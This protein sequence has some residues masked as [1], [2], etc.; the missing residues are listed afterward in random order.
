[1]PFPVITGLYAG[2]SLLLVLV[3]AYRI[4]VVRRATRTGLG[5]G[6]SRGL[7]QRVR[8]HGNAVEYLPMGLLGLMLLELTGHA[9]WLV[10]ALGATLVLARVLHAW[11]LSVS[12]GTSS[13]RFLGTL[14]SW[15]VLAAMA[16]LLV[17]RYF[18]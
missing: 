10:H 15:L 3:L 12:A 18:R 14:L 17:W 13:G 4:V 11:G 6:G 16:V 2:L 9:T 8:A 5:T 1:M 7:E